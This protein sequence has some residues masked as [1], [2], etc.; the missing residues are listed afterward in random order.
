MNGASIRDNAVE[1]HKNG[2]ER[3]KKSLPQ[4]GKRKATMHFAHFDIKRFLVPCDCLRLAKTILLYHSIRKVLPS[5]YEHK[6][7]CKNIKL[8]AYV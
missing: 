8:Y 6:I 5:L 2:G 1:V 7:I 4:A 3:D